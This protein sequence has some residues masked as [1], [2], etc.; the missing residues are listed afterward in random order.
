[1]TPIPYKLALGKDWGFSDPLNFFNIKFF[2]FRNAI[3]GHANCPPELK[4]FIEIPNCLDNF[5]LEITELLSYYKDTNITI[6]KYNNNILKIEILEWSLYDYDFQLVENIESIIINNNCKKI[7]EI[8]EIGYE[9]IYKNICDIY[10]NGYNYIDTKAKLGFTEN[11][12]YLNCY[13]TKEIEQE[14]LQQI[15]VILNDFEFDELKLYKTIINENI[16]FQIYFI[17]YKTLLSQKEKYIFNIEEIDNRIDE[18]FSVLNIKIGQ[19][20]NEY[21]KNIEVLF[22]KKTSANIG[23][24]Q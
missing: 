23:L 20:D 12:I 11:S 1:M 14:F 2:I 9:V 16:N 13:L 3:G 4:C 7:N 18:I 8:I 17:K 22:F 6:F 21:H 15:K 24:A 10:K 5:L 19:F